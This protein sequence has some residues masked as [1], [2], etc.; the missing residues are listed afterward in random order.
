MR[1]LTI[2]SYHKFWSQLAIS[3]MS[4][5]LLTDMLSGFSIIYLG[6]DIKA[7]LIYKVPLLILILG[8]IAQQD[9]FKFNILLFFIFLIFA[10][11]LYQFYEHARIDFFIIDFS[12]AI[13][14]LTPVCVFF[15]YREWYKN[16]P[17]FA[18][19]STH[20][21]LKYGFVI[22][23]INFIIGALGLGKSTYDFGQ[24]ETTGSTGLIMAG[25]ELGGAFLVV[26]TY[27]LHMC[28]NYKSKKWYLLLSIFTVL[29][30]LTVST[31]TT[32][33]ASL[34]IVFFVPIVNERRK[35]YSITLLKINI[36]LPVIIIIVVGVILVVELL[37]SL[38]LYGRMVFLYKKAGFLGIILSG[39]DI[40]AAD[41][42]NAVVH[43]SS[44]F[45]QLFGQGQALSLKR[46]DG[47]A[48]SEID[49]VDIFNFYGIFTFLSVLSFYIYTF[50]KAHRQTIK[51]INFLS[52]F[53]L[54]A[55]FTLLVLSQLSG[56]IWGS[57]TAGILVGV[58]LGALNIKDQSS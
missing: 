22:L 38:G 43:H 51:N 2:G 21:I 32:I 34:L 8:L 4:L 58:M 49:G 56:H 5:Y 9:I 35:L 55:S 44:L 48:T 54:L 23:S 53:I 37:Q 24:G 33:L 52:P 36:F 12:S 16:D 11:P 26:F 1:D 41:S 47:S 17:K 30:G 25:N 57:G 31:K 19:A 28:W 39:R 10:G 50:F 7:S 40:M 13:K 3:M 20:K 27:M 18:L 14:V 46:S 42:F 45:E 6:I 15:L 29:C